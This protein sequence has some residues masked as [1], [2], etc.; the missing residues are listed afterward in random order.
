MRIKMTKEDLLV[1]IRYKEKIKFEKV[2]ML[3]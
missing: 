3:F 2:S 1:K